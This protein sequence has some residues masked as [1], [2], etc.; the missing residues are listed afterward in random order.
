MKTINI[1]GLNCAIGC[2]VIRKR[3]EAFTISLPMA[4]HRLKSLFE[5]YNT[6][7]THLAVER[8]KIGNL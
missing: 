2:F 5:V 4:L 8:C 3:E 1:A 7:Q 6:F